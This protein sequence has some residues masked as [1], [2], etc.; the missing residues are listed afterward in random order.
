MEK[1]EDLEA[2]LKNAFES[3]KPAVLDMIVGKE[4][5]VLPMIPPGGGI[6]GMIGTERCRHV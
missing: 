2:A 5:K 3:G 1:P 4:D 6:S